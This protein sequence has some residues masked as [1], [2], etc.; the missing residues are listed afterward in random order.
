[1]HPTDVQELCLVYC[2]R[3]LAFMQMQNPL[4]DIMTIQ[5][6][7]PIT[8]LCLL[9]LALLCVTQAFA[10]AISQLGHMFSKA[11]LGM[12]LLCMHV[13]GADTEPTNPAL[14][15]LCTTPALPSPPVHV[16]I[17]CCYC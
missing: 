16:M 9:M 17:F 7:D 3:R 15:L 6:V 11:L 12:A 5:S 2:A 4:N 8:L 1:M 14:S 13:S 10:L